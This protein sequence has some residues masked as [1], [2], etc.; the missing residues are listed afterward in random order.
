MWYNWIDDFKKK[1]FQNVSAYMVKI[2]KI[3]SKQLA[4]KYDTIELTTS[5][6]KCFMWN[7]FFKSKQLERVRVYN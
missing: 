6:P 5:K 7:N 4:K 1:E 3:K 2:K